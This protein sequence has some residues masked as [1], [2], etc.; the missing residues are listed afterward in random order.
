MFIVQTQHV[1]FC[2]LSYAAIFIVKQRVLIDNAQMN[3]IS[4]KIL[5]LFSS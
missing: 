4:Q 5:E 1:H 3:Q 2:L